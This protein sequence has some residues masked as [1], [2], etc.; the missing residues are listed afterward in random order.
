MM[1]LFSSWP[2]V[3]FMLFVSE[4]SANRLCPQTVTV[5][6]GTNFTIP[7]KA[8]E[9]VNDFYWYRGH[10]RNKDLVGSLDTGTKSI[11]ENYKERYDISRSG[12]L[13]IIKA[14]IIHE[15]VYNLVKFYSNGSHDE[16]AV[17]VKITIT[18]DYTCPIINNCP[19]CVECELLQTNSSGTLV[20]KVEGSRPNM[21]LSWTSTSQT[22]VSVLKY[23]PTFQQRNGSID[24]WDSSVSLHYEIMDAC[25]NQ[26]VFQCNAKDALNILQ[27]RVTTITITVSTDL[28][29]GGTRT[30]DGTL[31]T[32][33]SPAIFAIVVAT[34]AILIGVFVVSYMIFRNR[35][36]RQPEYGLVPLPL[37]TRRNKPVEQLVWS[38]KDRYRKF[39]YLKPL[40]WGED[41]H[42]E[43]IYAESECTVKENGK[44]LKNLPKS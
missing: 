10:S 25:K 27:S 18:P 21:T 44:P 2:Y 16:E 33:K 13:L 39:C 9:N 20:C 24:S 36:Q 29:K 22:G 14:G 26:I 32:K 3:L 28:C 6:R 42:I 7:C 8:D 15:S 31:A 38:L 40:Q 34:V 12:A 23:Q 4:T 30:E 1:A 37:E 43:D 41:I 5:E 19:P 11:S 17:I 35:R